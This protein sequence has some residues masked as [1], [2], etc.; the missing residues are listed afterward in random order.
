MVEQTEIYKWEAT[1]AN[2]SVLKEADG[3]AFNLD[4]EALGALKM[5]LLRQVGGSKVYSINL[6]SGEFDKNGEKDT[7]IPGSLGDFGL[8]FFRRN[9]VRVDETGPLG[10]RTMYF[11][12]FNK[13]GTEKLLKVAPAIGMVEAEI[14]YAPR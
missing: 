14:G 13:S 10:Q 4:F 2:D 5:F 12:G 8:R 6:E 9:V 1:L 3:E 7:P 11:I